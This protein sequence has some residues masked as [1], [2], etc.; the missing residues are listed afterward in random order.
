MAGAS[1]DPTLLMDS[2]LPLLAAT[3]KITT[4]RAQ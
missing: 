1:P 2:L 4:L 3:T